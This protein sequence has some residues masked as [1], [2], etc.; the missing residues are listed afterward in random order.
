MIHGRSSPWPNLSNVVRFFEDLGA[1]E[2]PD[3]EETV[4]R[5]KDF[6][7]KLKEK[8]EDFQEQVKDFFAQSGIDLDE[9][10]KRAG[11]FFDTISGRDPRSD[12]GPKDANDE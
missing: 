6:S 7:E 4:E 8:G 10:M 12:D 2:A 3:A 5:V 1:K 11:E 9:G